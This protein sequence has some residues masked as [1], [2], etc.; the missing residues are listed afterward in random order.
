MNKKC[1][2]V[3]K[4]PGT[5]FM[6]DGIVGKFPRH[7]KSMDFMQEGNRLWIPISQD[8]NIAYVMEMSEEDV[9]AFTE[10]IAKLR[11]KLVRP[12][13]KIPPGKPS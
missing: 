5:S 3:L 4:N 7:L 13:Y 10:K 1:L 2:V 6:V 12:E 11:S 8:S 9:M